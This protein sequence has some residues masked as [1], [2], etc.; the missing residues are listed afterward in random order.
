VTISCTRAEV[1]AGAIALGE[2]TA[3]EREQY[4]QHIAG[5][6]RCLEALGGE[7]QIERV[8]ERV[9][10]ARDSETWAPVPVRFRER[11][12]PQRWVSALLGCA[13]LAALLVAIRDPFA[14]P[15]A[16]AR[17][18]SVPAPAS[19]PVIY[20]VAL[21]EV[22][23]QATPHRVAIVSR[24]PVKKVAAAPRMLVLHNVIERRGT[25][26]TQTTTETTVVAEAP[27]PQITAPPPSNVP[28]WR[29]DEALP[30]PQASVE[31]TAAPVL[32]G[33]AES[34][35]IGPV[36]ITRDPEP[37]GGDAAI[38]PRPAPI[39]Y[40]ENAYGTT[41]FEVTINERGAPVHCAITK[42]S[43]FAALDVAVC[44]AAMNARYSPR[45]I[46]GRAA[47]GVYRDAFTFRLTDPDDG[48][49]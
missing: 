31:P 46:N 40:A 15:H 25:H 29:R 41:A 37:I 23:P 24:P 1:F 33:H 8:M 34:L 12:H 21:D 44:R 32:A 10:S 16:H 45:L 3:A 7:R 49:L 26:V 19:T 20:H 4:R 2:A 43:G 48:Q 22:H 5:C 42:S 36:P 13:M 38:N 14:Q 27:I 35:A 17:V 39:A 30:K 47:V 11:A 28:I 9:A 6:A 18:A